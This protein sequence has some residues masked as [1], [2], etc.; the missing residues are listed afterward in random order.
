MKAVFA[1]LLASAAAIAP[2]TI[3]L[4][5]S[6][7]TSA[8]KLKRS[9]Y[10][11]HDQ[12]LTQPNGYKVHSRQDWTERCPAGK[13]TNLKNCPFPSPK[14]YDHQDK[15]VP[16]VTRV[17]LVDVDGTSVN[18]RVTS[19]NFMKRS[20]YLFKYDAHDRAGNWAEQVVFALI[21]DDK[22]APTI[23]VCRGRA[24]TVEAA[25]SWKLCGNSMSYDNI[26]GRVP[27]SY[28]IVQVKTG[29]RLCHKAKYTSARGKI[30]TH[31]VG[32]FIVTYHSCD[33]AGVYGRMARNNCARAHKGILVKDTRPPYIQVHGSVPTYHECSYKYS[34]AHATAT[35]LLDTVALGQFIKVSVRGRVNIRKLGNYK[36]T[37]NAKDRAGNKARTQYRPVKVVD[38][39]APVAHLRGPRN[40]IHYA[41]QRFKDRGAWCSDR[42]DKKLKPVRMTWSRPWND[43]K[44][45]DYIRT[46]HCKDFSRNI[47]YIT[48]KF[49]IVDKSKP[50]LTLVG[51]GF[52]IYEASRDIEYTDQGATC[53]D[54][55][56]GQ[57]S[58]AVEVSGQVVNMR[59][60]ATYRIRYDCQDLS[61]NKAVPVFR[62]VKIQDTI[63]PKITVRGVSLVY[64]EA[65]FPYVDAGATATDTLD[66]IITKKVWTDGDTVDTSNAFY[67]QR[68]CNGIKRHYKGAKS[69]MYY[70]TT[71]VY[72]K[73]SYTRVLVWCDM[74]RTNG[75][76]YMAIICGRRVIPYGS[77][78]GDCPK[79]GLKMA[80]F[81]SKAQL[82]RAQRKFHNN[83]LPKHSRFFPAKGATTD[84]Y[85]CSTNDNGKGWG[86]NTGRH[87]NTWKSSKIT[88]AEAGKYVIFY[89]VSDKAGNKECKTKKRTVI[90]KDSLP[91]VITLHMRQK[92]FNVGHA[93]DRKHDGATGMHRFF[94]VGHRLNPKNFAHIV[95]SKKAPLGNFHMLKSFKIARIVPNKFMAETTS[96][97][98]NAWIIGAIASAVTGVALIAYG[99]K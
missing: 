37:Y 77:K 29:I 24:E 20:T 92:M 91:P 46:Y 89:H 71:Y 15:A 59:I 63:C 19:V 33:R 13:A 40:I 74:G 68:T 14:A 3:E 95:R 82:K 62:K 36:L 6:A 10:R 27:I 32:R 45:G 75:H 22:R 73:R 84:Y 35:D 93:I 48:R 83:K 76:T 61:G 21:L 38:T 70:I 8:Y 12:G 66:G 44:L 2:P 43:R 5:M 34:D 18:T 31:Q 60:P 72:A 81:S 51:K 28:T 30:T 69:G 97:S 56:N 55:V 7:M 87:G 52:L 50:I 85:L 4:D 25:S 78:Q 16:V 86:I 90:V 42:C 57:L 80:K 41:Q 1:L 23:S 99:R 96:T 94:T 11:A 88:R 26:D 49:T 54:Y 9:I 67:S 65:G 47:G 98:A 79:F 39:I 17:Y 64:V 58:H 53:H